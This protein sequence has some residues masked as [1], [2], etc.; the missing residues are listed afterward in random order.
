MSLYT[1]IDS[2]LRA[3]LLF[4]IIASFGPPETHV[5]DGIC[6]DKEDGVWVSFCI[7]G[8]YRRILPNGEC[9]DIIRIPKEGGNYVVDSTLGGAE[10]RTLYM[11]IAD[12]TVE[13]INAGFQ[14]TARIDAIEVDVAAKL[15]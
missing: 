2:L 4:S 8:E 6:I 12:A 14:T 11:L 10:G 7:L 3:D 1:A 9:T 5:V 15:E 13:T